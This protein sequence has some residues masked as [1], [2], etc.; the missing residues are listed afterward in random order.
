MFYLSAKRV[1]DEAAERFALSQHAFCFVSKV[2]RDPQWRN[3][4]RFHRYLLNVSHMRCAIFLR[5]TIGN[6]LH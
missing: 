5:S 3:G 6:G 1:L 2:W 4:C